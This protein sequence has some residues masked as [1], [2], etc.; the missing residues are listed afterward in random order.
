M[1]QA[2]AG[3]TLPNPAS[4]GLHETIGFKPLCVYR[5]VGYKLGGWHDVGWWELI[6]QPHEVPPRP[7][8]AFKD[9]AGTDRVTAAL[10]AGTALLRL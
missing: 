10:Q 4:V 9:I 2:F 5:K 6:L 3:V 1:Y 7:L 8:Q